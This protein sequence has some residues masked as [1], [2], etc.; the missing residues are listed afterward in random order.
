VFNGEL[1]IWQNVLHFR[2]TLSE[3]DTRN[4]S[5]QFFIHTRAYSILTTTTTAATTTTTTTTTNNNNNNNNN[6]FL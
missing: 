2:I 6:S 5:V 1:F 4:N 3:L